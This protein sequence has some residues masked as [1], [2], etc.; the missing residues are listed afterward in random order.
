MS[1]KCTLIVVVDLL[2]TIF[3]NE[4]DVIV[5]NIL[6]VN[7]GMKALI[8]HLY[9]VLYSQISLKF[10]R[11]QVIIYLYDRLVENLLGEVSLE[12]S[13][14]RPFEFCLRGNLPKVETKP[15]G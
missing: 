13:V 1:K 10:L 12:V 11:Y 9:C 3:T 2:E 8:Y 4:I 7:K 6:F 15:L 5:K 14:D